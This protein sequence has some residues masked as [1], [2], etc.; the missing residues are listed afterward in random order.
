MYPEIDHVIRI[1]EQPRHDPVEHSNIDYGY[2]FCNTPCTSEGGFVHALDNRHCLNDPTRPMRSTDRHRNG[3]R[4]G[5]AEMYRTFHHIAK[6]KNF[7]PTPLTERWK[8]YAGS[9]REHYR[10]CALEQT[11]NPLRDRPT[12]DIY[13]SGQV[14]WGEL[15][16]RS[17]ALLVQS[18]RARGCPGVRA[19]EELRLPIAVEGPYRDL[20]E[21]ALH[22]WCSA[23]KFRMVASGMNLFKRARVLKKMARPGYSLLSV[24]LKNFDGMSGDNAIDERSAFLNWAVRIWGDN[25]DLAKVIESQNRCRIRMG[26]VYAQVYGNRGS[27]TAG[28]SA[29][30]KTVM[31][32]ALKYAM[33]PAFNVSDFLSDGDDTEV[34]VPD[35]QLVHVRS[36]VRR[37]AALGFVVKIDQLLTENDGTPI[38]D[39]LRFCRAGIIETSR[40]PLLCKDP[41]DAL[42]VMTNFR[43][44]FMGNQFKDYLQTLCVGINAVYGDVPILHKLAPLFDIGGK[45][46]RTLCESS[47]IEYM[48]GRQHD[49]GIAGQITEDHRWSFYRTFGV[50]PAEQRSAESA[51]DQLTLRFRHDVLSYCTHKNPP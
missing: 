38:V 47:G 7:Q 45:I 18:V 42:K 31:L 17:R 29:G 35:T 4:R 51:L 13:H 3:F 19:G 24:D 32:A 26:A 43:R 34:W 5:L 50:P 9:T 20:L 22:A 14:K 16:E 48:M 41:L 49:I 6:T 12:S 11:H 21:Q 39:G 27:G 37:L 36:W 8:K 1:L 46:D 15:S 44:H 30:N 33:G 2:N 28:T 10:K 40:G 23:R 25:P